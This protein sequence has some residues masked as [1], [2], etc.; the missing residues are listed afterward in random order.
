MDNVKE[1]DG[2]FGRIQGLNSQIKPQKFF[3]FGLGLD[4]IEPNAGQFVVK[5]KSIE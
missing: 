3:A 5:I 4:L 1:R 2:S